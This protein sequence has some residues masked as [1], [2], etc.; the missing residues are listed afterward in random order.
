MNRLASNASFTAYA[1]APTAVATMRPAPAATNEPDS[2]SIA[3]PLLDRFRLAGE[4]RLVQ[5]EPVGREHLAVHDHLHAG[6]QLQDVIQDHT[7]DGHLLDLGRPG[8][9]APS[10]P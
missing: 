10:G 3:R 5:L 8:R 6:R 9:H 4:E 7:I 1:S 2:A